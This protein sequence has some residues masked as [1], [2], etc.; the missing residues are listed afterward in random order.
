MSFP[1]TQKSLERLQDSISRMSKADLPTAHQ[2]AGVKMDTG[3]GDDEEQIDPR[4][5]GINSEKQSTSA[6]TEP[7]LSKWLHACTDWLGVSR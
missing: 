1:S 4:D 3:A 7:P 2:P 5:R 6:G